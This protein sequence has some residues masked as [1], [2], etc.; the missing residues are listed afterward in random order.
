MSQMKKLQPEMMKIKERFGDDRMKQQEAMMA[1]Y[2]KQ[3]V[4]PLSGCLP[5]VVQIPVFFALYKV[6]YVTIEM[7]HAPFYGWIRDLSAP[8]PTS[9]FNLFGLLP[10]TPPAMLL[11]GVL[12]I[13]MGIT[14]WVQMK[15]NPTPPDPIQAKLFNLMPLVF[16]FILAPFPAGLVLYWTWNNLLSITQQ[17]IIMRRQ[18][19]DINLLENIRESLPS[20]GRKKAE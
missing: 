10:F 8:D 1:L 9:L 17:Y 4:S 7:R 15:L 16:T 3:K 20:F 13:L 19:V 5:V 11:I 14:M 12:P 6:L 18:G 2:K